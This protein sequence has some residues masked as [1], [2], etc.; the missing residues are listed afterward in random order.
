MPKSE[1]KIFEIQFEK[2]KLLNNFIDNYK[3]FIKY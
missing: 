1:R 2:I 3:F